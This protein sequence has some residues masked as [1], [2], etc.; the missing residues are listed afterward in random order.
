[1]DRGWYDEPFVKQF[2]DLPLLV[3]TD[4][5]QRLKASDVFPDYKLGLS[6]DGPSYTVHGL[7]DEQYPAV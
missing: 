2:T 7:K 5:L 3:R 6:K 1:M 4:T